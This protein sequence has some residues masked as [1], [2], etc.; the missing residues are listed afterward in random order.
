MGNSFPPVTG[1][2]PYPA[3][4]PSM[5]AN[6]NQGNNGIPGSVKSPGGLVLN[7]F[8]S[9]FTGSNEGVQQ[10]GGATDSFQP[11]GMSNTNNQASGGSVPMQQQANQ[12]NPFAGGSN[13]PAMPSGVDITDPTKL[14]PAEQL[15]S[16]Y[17]KYNAAQQQQDA[18]LKAVQDAERARNDYMALGNN[19]RNQY[20]QPPNPTA[21]PFPNSVGGT[22]D[23]GQTLPTGQVPGQSNAQPLTPGQPLSG[24]GLPGQNP[25]ALPPG[26]SQTG[27]PLTPQQTALAAQALRQSGL[28]PQ[29]QAGMNPAQQTPGRQPDASATDGQ[30]GQ[31]ATAQPQQ[32]PT[33]ASQRPQAASVSEP[34]APSATPSNLTGAPAQTLNKLIFSPEELVQFKKLTPREQIDW[35]TQR[36]LQTK[37]D[38]IGEIAIQSGMPNGSKFPQETY[39]RL[40]TIAKLDTKDIKG[41]AGDDLR[42]FRKTALWTLGL[43]NGSQNSST[44]VQSLP[45]IKTIESI[46]RDPKETTDIRIA[47]A[48]A[49]QAINRGND[50]AMQQTL[51]RVYSNQKSA[52]KPWTWLRAGTPTDVRKIVD[53]ARKGVPIQ[54]TQPGAEQQPSSQMATPPASATAVA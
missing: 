2:Q 15:N 40:E 47:A 34:G 23:A 48:Q 54:A 1:S 29:D 42:Y 44:P 5:G 38:A 53:S 24:Q 7:F 36:N 33:G 32:Q 13:A 41:P 49:L 45:A 10:P 14:S 9:N 18:A 11:S 46:A 4:N 50:P 12:S 35:I 27:Q 21:Q 8:G 6:R 43:L 31:T 17:N 39:E 22:V 19:I 28:S 26:N 37:A 52:V 25:A 20:Q 16:L 30:S 3:G 51:K